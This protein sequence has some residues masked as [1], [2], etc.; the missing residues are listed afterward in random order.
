MKVAI[1][2]HSFIG[3][4]RDFLTETGEYRY[5]SFDINRFSVRYVGKDGWTVEKMRRLRTIPHTN[6]ASKH[7]TSTHCR[8][9]IVHK[10]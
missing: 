3:R 2:G 7:C 6:M 5:Y 4:L 8:F 9:H 10:I 1:V